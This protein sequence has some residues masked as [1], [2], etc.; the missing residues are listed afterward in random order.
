MISSGRSQELTPATTQQQQQQQQQ[1]QP[2]HIHHACKYIDDAKVTLPATA[3]KHGGIGDERAQ[4][5]TE[6]AKQGGR[7]PSPA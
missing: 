7:V 2:T 4:A 3:S 5:A 6:H 1:Q